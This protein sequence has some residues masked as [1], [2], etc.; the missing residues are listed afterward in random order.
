MLAPM[1]AVLLT[2]AFTGSAAA[3]DKLVTLNGSIHAAE[4]ITP[5]PGSP[6]VS[7][8]ADGTGGGIATHLGLFTVTWQFTV[9]LAD[10]TGT[11]PVTFIAANGDKIFTTA[12]GTSGPTGTPGVFHIVELQTVTGGTGRFANAKGTLSVDRLTDLNTGLT[13]GSFSAII[14]LPG[15]AH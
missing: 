9:L 1:A 11:G 14:T 8:V 2:A 10:G 6:P 3:A 13:S 4:T 12:A 5:T 7:F 15:E